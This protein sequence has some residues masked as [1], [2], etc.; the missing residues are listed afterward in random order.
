MACGGRDVE[1][2]GGEGDLDGDIVGQGGLGL[3]RLWVD[4]GHPWLPKV[5]T[6]VIIPCSHFHREDS[7]R[8]RLDICRPKHKK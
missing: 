2:G 1:E 3:F 4:L 5:L 6:L 7:H 8:D